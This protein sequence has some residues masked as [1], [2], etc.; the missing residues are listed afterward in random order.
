VILRCRICGADQPVAVADEADEDPR[1][2]AIRQTFRRLHAE[3]CGTGTV[4]L[5][6]H[7]P[8]AGY[9]PPDPGVWDRYLA[10][11]SGKPPDV[12][13]GTDGL[14]SR[15]VEGRSLRVCE[16]CWQTIPPYRDFPQ[17]LISPESDGA[18]GAV[19]KL[20]VT[21]TDTTSPDRAL[22]ALH[23][24]KVV[25]LPCYYHAFQRV[26]PGAVLPYLSESLID[27][28]PT[29]TPDE[30]LPLDRWVKPPKPVEA[31]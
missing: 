17:G 15:L 21:T 2:R 18:G 4:S 9:E 20:Q 13:C 1:T 22:A 27:L 28:V 6:L 25:C 14:F 30:A 5:L 8:T 11:L 10:S 12:T 26:Y 29:A 23:V 31:A 3:T 16:D 19:P 24:R 7:D